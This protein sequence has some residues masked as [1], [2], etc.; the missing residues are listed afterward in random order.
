M[1]AACKKNNVKRIIFVSSSAAS[2]EGGSYAAS[3]F[4]SEKLVRESGLEW[5]IL[6]ISE[7]YGPNLNEGIA[8]LMLCVKTR[9]VVPVIGNGRYLL[10]PVHVDDVT[11]AMAAVL[12]HSSGKNDTL[13]LCGPEKMTMNEL[14]S[15]LARIEN[16]NPPNS[17]GFDAPY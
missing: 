8:K 4:R 17:C 6:R 7:V 15:R 12:E 5:V 11:Q 9:P 3:N 13:Y 2:E 16:R 14:I 10:S 1:I